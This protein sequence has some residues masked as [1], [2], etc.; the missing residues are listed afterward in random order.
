MHPADD[1]DDRADRTAI[2]GS[3]LSMGDGP[4]RDAHSSSGSSSESESDDDSNTGERP[5]AAAALP[6]DNLVRRY[7]VG[8][9]PQMWIKELADARAKLCEPSGPCSWFESPR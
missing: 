8:S 9:N 3:A 7:G 5:V 2:T 1:E 6:A 4:S